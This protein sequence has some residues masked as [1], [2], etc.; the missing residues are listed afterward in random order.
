MK[1]T[2]EWK[3]VRMPNYTYNMISTIHLEKK[4]FKKKHAKMSA[5]VI[6]QWQNYYYL[7]S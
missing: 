5:V 6:S 2:Y 7:I 3:E 4:K 1:K